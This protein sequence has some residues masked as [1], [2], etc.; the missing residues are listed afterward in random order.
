[1]KRLVCPS[2]SKTRK[3]IFLVLALIS[4]FG[5]LTF[6]G[7]SV[8][9][10]LITVTKTR[11]PS[12]ADAAALGAAQEIVVGIR[13]AGEQGVTELDRV[14]AIAAAAASD[15]A[16]ESSELNGFKINKSVDVVF[17]SRTLGPDGPSF[18]ERWGVQPYNMVKVTIRK[19]KPG[20]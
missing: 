20:P 18:V 1:M 5:T 10:G 11:M 14:Q 13:K 2:D 15:M 12:A 6:V 4:L 9:L 7:M 17:G 8:D 16:E 19:T 3:G